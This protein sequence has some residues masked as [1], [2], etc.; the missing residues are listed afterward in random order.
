MNYNL[1][2][3]PTRDQKPREAG[4]TMAMDKGLSVREV[5]DFIEVAG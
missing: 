3:L 1:N 5:E 4:Y 2:N